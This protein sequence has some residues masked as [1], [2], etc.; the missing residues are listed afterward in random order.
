[1]FSAQRSVARQLGQLARRT[2]G[3][4]QS[5][6]RQRIPTALILKRAMATLDYGDEEISESRQVSRPNQLPPSKPNSIAKE[7]I[8]THMNK[9]HLSA[10]ETAPSTIPPTISNLPSKPTTTI[11]EQDAVFQF[12]GRSN[13]STSNPPSHDFS[14]T[15]APPASLPSIDSYRPPPREPARDRE[16][17]RMG[18]RDNGRGRYGRDRQD[19]KPFQPRPALAAHDRPILKLL[20]R[21]KTPEQYP[22]MVQTDQDYSV[23]DG[24]AA[25]D[26]DSA[27]ED[28]KSEEGVIEHIAKRV[29]TDGK[30]DS[31]SEETAA[32]EKKVDF[33]NMIRSIKEAAHLSKR[34]AVSN[35]DD[36]ISLAV[37]DPEDSS[38]EETTPYNHEEERNR[39]SAVLGKPVPAGPAFSHRE[40]HHSSLPQPEPNH[41]P[42]ME[43]RERRVI[44]KRN[45]DDFEASSGDP[46]AIQYEMRGNGTNRDTPWLKSV[47]KETHEKSLYPSVW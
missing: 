16:R 25:M 11:P 17:N 39:L 46:G 28:K 18:N 10:S 24:E 44:G 42:S 8:Q 41:V 33:I 2:T 14:F 9:L 20:G 13:A 37:S 1:L 38:G 23:D 26:L 47:N 12:Q 34:N 35:N 29:K 32:P 43:P 5:N 6:Y 30:D 27:D 4:A 40:F 15:H 21:E 36:F 19:R 3:F 45:H 31:K 22:A 7:P